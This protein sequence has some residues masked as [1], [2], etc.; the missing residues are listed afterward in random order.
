MVATYKNIYEY[1]EAA[2]HT[3]TLN[4]TNNECS[5]AVQKYIESQKVNWQLVESDNHRVNASECAIQ[6]CKNHVLVGLASVDT[7]F[8]V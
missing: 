3:Y 6:T 4:I 8:A 7:S 5:K 2:G 1:L